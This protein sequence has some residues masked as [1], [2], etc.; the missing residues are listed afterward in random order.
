VDAPQLGY[1]SSHVDGVIPERDYAGARIEPLEPV[2]HGNPHNSQMLANGSAH[3]IVSLR[4]R[5]PL[6]DTCVEV[7]E[8]VPQIGISQGRVVCDCQAHT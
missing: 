8:V 2:S 7:L 5:E 6:F 3:E 4:L 1:N